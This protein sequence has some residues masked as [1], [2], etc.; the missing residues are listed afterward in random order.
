MT[1]S[2]VRVLNVEGNHVLQDIFQGF[3][4]STRHWHSVVDWQPSHCIWLGRVNFSRGSFNRFCNS[5]SLLLLTENFQKIYK[6]RL[7]ILLKLF[8]LPVPQIWLHHKLQ[9]LDYKLC[10]VPLP[11]FLVAS[12]HNSSIISTNC[13]KFS[14]SYPN[15]FQSVT[16]SHPQNGVFSLSTI[17]EFLNKAALI[18][19]PSSMYLTYVMSCFMLLMSVDSS[20]TKETQAF[21]AQP[22]QYPPEMYLQ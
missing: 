16:A 19:M 5:C 17:S 3:Q 10:N 22:C 11:N 9:E 20:S 18:F 2:F 6:N 1:F 4:W 7:Q 13:C 21:L 15:S 8:F 12:C 14:F